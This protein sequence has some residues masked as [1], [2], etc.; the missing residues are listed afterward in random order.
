MKDLVTTGTGN[1]RNLKSSI[2]AGTSWEDALDMLRAGTFPI[3]LNGL[4]ED[5][6]STA[7]S[8]YNKANVLPDP[9]CTDLGIPSSTAEPKDAFEALID[10]TDTVQ[11]NLTSFLESSWPYPY[12][13]GVA[14]P[15]LLDNWFFYGGGSQAGGGRFPINQQ[16]QTSKSTEGYFC[17]RWRKSNGNGTVSL[18][19]SGMQ[20]VGTG[21]ATAAIHQPIEY[22]N[23]L[24]GRQVTVSMLNAAGAT[25]SATCTLPSNLPET[26]TQYASTSAVGNVTVAIRGDSS[27][28]Y[29]QLLATATSSTAIVAVKLELGPNQTLARQVGS[30]WVPTE[31]PNFSIEL[32]TCQRFMVVFKKTASG[33]DSSYSTDGIGFGSFMESR[34][35]YGFIPLPVEMRTT[36][37][38]SGTIAAHFVDTGGDN[39]YDTISVGDISAKHIHPNGLS[40]RS[41]DTYATGASSYYNAAVILAATTRGCVL[42]ANL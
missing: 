14:R 41:Q 21:S 36:P 27:F 6:V 3:D 37:T 2:P 24:L 23:R 35:V 29:V 11:A 30:I 8:A 42:D 28:F 40:F 16:G 7:G 19:T 18:L 20:I 38:L 34:Y 13:Q 32:L 5:G 15:N 12:K 10:R 25:A 31:I 26:D 1:S 4:N 22:S 33:N 17:D 9:L 39:T